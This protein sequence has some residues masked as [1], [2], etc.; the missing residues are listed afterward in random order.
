MDD[1]AKPKPEEKKPEAKELKESELEKVTG[2]LVDAYLI[3]D[4]RD[5][6]STSKK[7]DTVEL[8]KPPGPLTPL[9]RP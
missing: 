4:G 9:K 8:L 3:I 7:R 5:G 2:G 1:T 6:E